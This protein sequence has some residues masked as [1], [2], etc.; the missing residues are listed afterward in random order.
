MRLVLTYGKHDYFHLIIIIIRRD[1]SSKVKLEFSIIL[2]FVSSLI[3]DLLIVNC[4][5]VGFGN[6]QHPGQQPSRPRAFRQNLPNP[7]D[8]TDKTQHPPTRID[9]YRMQFHVLD[10]KNLNPP[11]QIQTQQDLYSLPMS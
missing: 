4:T 3:Y 10:R 5:V 2:S 9:V 8:K 11:H 7:N 6:P 1:R